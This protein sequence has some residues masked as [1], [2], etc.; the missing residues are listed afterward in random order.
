MRGYFRLGYWK[1]D[2]KSR[3]GRKATVKFE[4]TQYATKWP[5]WQGLIE[6]SLLGIGSNNLT[7]DYYF[8]GPWGHKICEKLLK[9]TLK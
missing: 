5:N 4:E 8:E 9:K 7:G 6:L 3:N 2:W 1:I